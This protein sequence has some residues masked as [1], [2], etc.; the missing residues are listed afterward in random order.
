LKNLEDHPSN[1]V[2]LKERRA[3]DLP[4][5]EKELK[6]LVEFASML[7]SR[8]R[9]SDNETVED[10]H[11]DADLREKEFGGSGDNNFEEGFISETN[12][13]A[14]RKMKVLEK[15][16]EVTEDTEEI[17]T[18]RDKVQQYCDKYEQHFSFYCVGDID[19]TGEHKEEIA[20]FC[21]S[22][23]NACPHKQIT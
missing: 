11:T 17:P 12:G 8:F 10:P 9:R 3:H 5:N 18:H 6:V 2:V 7:E 13:N 22:Y 16:S 19:A 15:E 23:K 20:Q 21:P 1:G 14:N 4:L